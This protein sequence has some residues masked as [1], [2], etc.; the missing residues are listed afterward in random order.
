MDAKTFVPLKGKIPYWKKNTWEAWGEGMLGDFHG[1][2]EG[3][4]SVVM[5]AEAE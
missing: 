1:E 5:A 3:R 2:G 4:P